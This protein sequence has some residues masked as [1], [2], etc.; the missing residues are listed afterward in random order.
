MSGFQQRPRESPQSWLSRLS[1]VPTAGLSL[2]QRRLHIHYLADARRLLQQEQ[3]QARWDRDR[4]RSST[5]PKEHRMS[6]QRKAVA[7][8]VDPEGLVG[9]WQALPDWH[10]EIK[11]GASM[12]SLDKDWNPGRADLLVV[13]AGDDD[14]VTLGLCRDLPSQAGRAVA[15][16]LVLI[17]PAREALARAVLLAGATSCLILPVHAHELLRSVTPALGGRTTRPTQARPTP[18]RARLPVARS[19]GPGLAASASS[20]ASPLTK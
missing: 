19:G 5:L 12:G 7:F 2:A 16:L 17:P 6:N 14:S 18:G 11:N 10:I 9:L 1:Q 4:G 15:P 20:F 13:R 8:D 3:Q